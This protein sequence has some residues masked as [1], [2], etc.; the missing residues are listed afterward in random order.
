MRLYIHQVIQHAHGKEP[1]NFHLAQSIEKAWFWRTR[2]DAERA[3]SIW[4][5]IRTI[6]DGA[7]CSDVKVEPRPNGGFH[8]SFE[9]PLH[10][11]EQGSRN[12]VQRF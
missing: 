4:Q 12:D 9:S 6:K 3:L 11:L 1:T 7:E 10:E 8:I 2:A 5:G